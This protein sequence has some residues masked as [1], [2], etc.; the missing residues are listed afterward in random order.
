MARA[1]SMAKLFES[2]RYQA[3]M[4]AINMPDAAPGRKNAFYNACGNDV[5]TEEKDWLWHYLQN[6]FKPMD[7]PYSEGHWKKQ[8]VRDVTAQSGW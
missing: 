5:T 2:N 1:V 3:I 4:N 8:E 7:P 6:C